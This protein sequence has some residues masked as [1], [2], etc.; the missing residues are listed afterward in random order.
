ML[1]KLTGMVSPAGSQGKLTILI[2]HRV[3]PSVDPL[4]PDQIDAR[5]FDSICRWIKSWFNVLPLNEAVSCLKEGSLPARAL[6]ITFDDGY[7]DNH[8]FALPILKSHEISA[9]FF[10]ATGYLNGGRM[11]NDTVIEA[12][13]GSKVG[14]LD[15]RGLDQF[16]EKLGSLQ[17]VS[18]EEKRASIESI[19]SRIK[20]LPGDERTKVAATI[21]ERCG[22]ALPRNM[23]MTSE[24]LVAMRKA[25]M[26]IGAHTVS[27]PIL[28]KLNSTEVRREILE[29]KTTL[30][31]ML[32]VDIRLFAYPNGKPNIDYLERD[33][34]L[35]SDMGFDAAFST[36]WG[37]A[38]CESD[39]M[40]L[41]RFTPWDQI[42]VFFGLRLLWS[43]LSNGRLK[44]GQIA[45]EG[46]GN[47]E[48]PVRVVK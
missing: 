11:W 3:L 26:T 43:M 18:V 14:K 28:A 42:S 20:Y 48:I 27:H 7:A 2:F 16:E 30:E 38:D 21:A 8:D 9:A 37:V 6:S 24:Q 23:M 19:I 33:A 46:S 36:A 45:G 39:L 41:P 47:R 35:L 15:L 13:R 5:R 1:K 44:V 12:I 17:I 32:Q 22:A 29:G 10:I 31:S 25:G 4:F 40:Q 34:R